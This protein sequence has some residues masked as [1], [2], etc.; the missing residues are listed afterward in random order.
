MCWQL[1]SSR[2]STVIWLLTSEQWAL[3]FR[4]FHFL[5][6]LCLTGHTATSHFVH[7]CTLPFL[8]L[9][10]GT[11]LLRA[12]MLCLSP[13]LFQHLWLGGL[14]FIQR[15]PLC[16]SY[17]AANHGISTVL[18]HRLTVLL[19]FLHAVRRLSFG[20][21]VLVQVIYCSKGGLIIFPQNQQQH[22]RGD[23]K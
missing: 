11:M 8:L 15:L 12:K 7:L 18:Y 20:S 14:E 2:L 16:L 5:V 3:A 6:E 19:I 23:P 1:T 17:E 22:M 4:L 10:I 21:W 9:H 13:M